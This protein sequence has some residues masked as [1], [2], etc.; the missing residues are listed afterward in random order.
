VTDLS[1]HRA[2]QRDAAAL[3][4][5]VAVSRSLAGETDLEAILDSVVKHGRALVS[6]RALAVEVREGSGMA[7]TA[8]AGDLP[9]PVSPRESSEGA[10]LVVPLLL[11][12]RTY[13]ALVA[14]ATEG[15][16]SRF[17]IEDEE[18]LEAFAALVAGAVAVE[19]LGEA[20]RPLVLDQFGVAA[21][22]ESLADRIEVPD[23]EIRTRI[24]LA[25]EEGRA[26]ERLHGDLEATI[27]RIVEEALRNAA[28]QTEASRVLLEVVED[29]HLEEIRI[30][31]R[32]SPGHG[33][34]VSAVLPSDRGGRSM[35]NID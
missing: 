16:G 14:V 26:T 12:G 25:F 30:E 29:D 23:L 17:T 33:A 24:D 22:I 19:G 1:N 9:E 11:R 7:V 6:A 18:L 2:L 34:R 4:A 5:V 35:L 32:S 15:D 10:V 13:G 21:A 3:D 28:G 27:Y 20:G 31:V 8:S